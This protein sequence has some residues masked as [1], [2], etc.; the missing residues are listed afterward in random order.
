MR[1]RG[2]VLAMA[3][4]PV[5]A[6]QPAPSPSGSPLAVSTPTV[7]AA[8][9]IDGLV[10]DLNR[11]G[12]TAEIGSDFLSEPIGGQ[13]TTVCFEAQTVRVYEFIDHEAALAASAKIDRDDPSM[14]GNGV[15]EWTGQPRFW[16]RDKIIVL[17]LGEDAATDRALRALLGQPFA[18]SSDPGRGFLP[19][20]PCA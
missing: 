3:I 11:E 16:L 4:L 9:G 6:C 7:T 12:P 19:D 10:A 8:Q 20:P 5:L 14:I 15:V 1:Q 18:E 2:L 17:Y 13:G